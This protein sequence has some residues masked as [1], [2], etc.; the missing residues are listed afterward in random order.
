MGIF[1]HALT[2]SALK[3]AIK[4]Q[5]LTI[6]GIPVT[7]ATYIC[8]GEIIVFKYDK[9][10]KTAKIPELSF[11]ILFQDNYLAAIV[12]PA[13]VLVSGNKFKT[14]ANALP[15]HLQQSTLPDAC[16]PQPV[17]RLD[18]GT[19][20]VLLIGKTQN[21]IRKLNKMFENKEIS[22]TYF[23]VTAGQMPVSGSISTTIEQKVSLTH[24]AVSCQIDSEKYQFLNLVKLDP[25]TGRRHQLRIHLLDIG[26]PIL[27][28]KIYG[29]DHLSSQTKGLHLHSFSV[30]FTH[31]FTHQEIYLEAPLPK[32]FNSIFKRDTQL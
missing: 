17:H 15:H 4:K 3:K 19:S 28:D 29:K 5:Q 21:S 2:K 31:P 1:Q 7:T 30:R 8:G 25:K 6:D 13:G 20:G 32:R 24:F 12:K 23:A 9:A 11:A 10:I 18:F 26:H 27:G 22:K 14:I 16:I